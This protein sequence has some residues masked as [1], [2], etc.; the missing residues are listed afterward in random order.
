MK[1]ARIESP[2]LNNDSH[3]AQQA[4]IPAVEGDQRGEFRGERYNDIRNDID[5]K[6][7]GKTDVTYIRY[8]R[9]LAS[10]STGVYPVNDERIAR[11]LR[12]ISQT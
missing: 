6:T 7:Y 11:K 3:T 1:G 5:V 10:K 4:Q 2:Q 9:T 12:L 8:R